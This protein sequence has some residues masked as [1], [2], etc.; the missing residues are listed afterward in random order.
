MI[1]LAQR[2]DPMPIWFPFLFVAFWIFISHR[3]A[4]TGWRAFAERHGRSGR[5]K[6]PSFGSP[7]TRFNCSWQSNYAN[8]VRVVPTSEGLWFST[9]ILFRAF[10]PPFFVPWSFVS[11][12][13]SL[14]I[15]HLRG[16]RLHIAT[17]AGTI[18][19]RLRWT[20]RQALI[21]Y[22]PELLTIPPPDTTF[23]PADV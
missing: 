17:E 18:A 23:K 2:G 11:R 12:V 4:Q 21:Q 6:R 19:V 13:D 5:P 16:Y 1:F 22:R 3:V 14:S 9:M 8:V 15:W 7:Q 20:F 10:H